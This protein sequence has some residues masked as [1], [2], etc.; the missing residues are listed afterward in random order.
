MNLRINAIKLIDPNTTH[1]YITRYFYM[2]NKIRNSCDHR[3][4][5][6]YVVEDKELYF[7]CTTCGAKSY[8]TDESSTH[9]ELQKRCKNKHIT[10]EPGYVYA[11]K[12]DIAFLLRC[13]KCGKLIA[14]KKR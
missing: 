8:I 7:I 4:I 6:S 14:Q 13:F 10:S 11:D 3:W 5:L 12:N 2:D 9:Q 1:A